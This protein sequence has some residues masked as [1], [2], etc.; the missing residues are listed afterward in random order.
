MELHNL[1][2]ESRVIYIARWKWFLILTLLALAALPAV[3]SLLSRDAGLGGQIPLADKQKLIAYERYSQ[4]VRDATTDRSATLSQKMAALEQ[5][6]GAA[7]DNGVLPVRSAWPT[8]G[9]QELLQMYLDN[10][11]A[12]SKGKAF[13]AYIRQNYPTYNFRE[14]HNSSEDI[15]H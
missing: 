1:D 9:E 11:L 13:L 4:K 12:T 6:V 2:Y 5:A 15:S 14:P 10:A 3:V 7:R 8:T